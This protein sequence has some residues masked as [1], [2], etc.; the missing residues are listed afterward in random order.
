MG[1]SSLPPADS[2]LPPPRQKRKEPVDYHDTGYFQNQYDPYYIHEEADA[3]QSGDVIIHPVGQNMAIIDKIKIHMR[4]HYNQA[5]FSVKKKRFKR[6]AV[7]TDQ[8]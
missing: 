6:P 3:I 1:Q 2:H 5:V 4:S 7:L 8:Q